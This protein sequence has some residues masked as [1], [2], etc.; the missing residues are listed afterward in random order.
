MKSW[1]TEDSC[2]KY[3]REFKISW[4]EASRPYNLPPFNLSLIILQVV[5]GAISLDYLDQEKDES[6]YWDLMEQEKQQS[7]TNYKLERLLQQFQVC[8]WFKSFQY[9][10]LFHALSPIFTM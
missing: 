10:L 1:S 4:A 9:M 6:W 8:W 3:L 2:L 5:Y 7:Y